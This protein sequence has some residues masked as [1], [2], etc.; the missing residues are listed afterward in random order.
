MAIEYIN[1]SG[2]EYLKF[3][4]EERKEKPYCIEYPDRDK[5]WLVNDKFHR[6]DG[7]S[8]IYPDG[9]ICWYLNGIRYSFEEWLK[10][11]T[12]SDE[13]KVFMRLKYND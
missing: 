10:L 12:I 7:P 8:I 6:E 13:E 9:T 2:E 3:S 5:F 4:I 1:I 11:T